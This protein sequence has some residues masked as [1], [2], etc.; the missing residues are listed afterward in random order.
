VELTQRGPIMVGIH[1]RTL[2]LAGRREEAMAIRAE[3]TERARLEYIGPGAFLQMIGL[4]LGDDD[5]TATLLRS[6][7]EAE[8]GPTAIY[9]TVAPELDLLLS[10]PRL[11][12]LVRQ[13]SLYAQRPGLPPMRR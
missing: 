13:L 9:T 7:V 11:G 6:N 10:H 12:P 5:A 4:D 8:T 1:G 3:L 2:A